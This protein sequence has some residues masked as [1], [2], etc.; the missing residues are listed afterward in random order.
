MD[1]VEKIVKPKMFCGDKQEFSTVYIGFVTLQD[2]GTLK[3]T[4]KIVKRITKDQAQEIINNGEYGISQVGEHAQEDKNVLV[5]EGW[6]YYSVMRLLG[7]H[8]EQFEEVANVEDYG[9]EDDTTRCDECGML[10]SNDDGYVYNF[11]H[12]EDLGMLGTN[13]GCF[14]E[15]C[16]LNFADTYANNPKQAIERAAATDLENEGKIERLE[17]FIGGMVDGRGG[18]F[19]GKPTREGTPEAILREYQEKMP[20]KTFMFIHEESGQF[21]QYFSIAEIMPEKKAA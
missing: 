14:D 1:M 13:C 18:Y 16:K 5:K 8:H 21:Q 15:H 20:E 17:T 19:E 2:K 7:Y 4:N 9:F 12:V 10:D 11:R 3:P 6:N